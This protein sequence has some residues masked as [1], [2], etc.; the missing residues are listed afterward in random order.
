M[1]LHLFLQTAFCYID[2]FSGFSEASLLY[3]F[4]YDDSPK[5]CAYNTSIEHDMSDLK[6]GI[7]LL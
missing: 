1:E 5:L 4:Y 2:M 7:F 6:L 3:K